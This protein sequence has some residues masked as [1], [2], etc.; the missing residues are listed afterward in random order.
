[1]KDVKISVTNKKP[2]YQQVF[3]Q[4][5]AQII[6]GDM[7]KDYNL[8]SIRTAAKEL[9][10]SIITIKKVWEKLESTGLIYTVAG[11]GS[12]VS[13]LSNTDLSKKVYNRIEGKLLQ[14]LKYYKSLDITEEELIDFIKKNF[15]KLN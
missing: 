4:V 11:V 2:L 7:K 12:F 10:V 5:S 6:K 15:S 3:E 13:D 8:P 1:M 14:D 9:R